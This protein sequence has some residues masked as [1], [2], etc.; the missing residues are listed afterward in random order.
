MQPL[1]EG[2]EAK[3][4]P[5]SDAVVS[6]QYCTITGDQAAETCTS[7]GTGWYKKSQPLRMCT[8]HAIVE[9]K[10]E[11]ADTSTASDSNNDSDDEPGIFDRLRDNNADEDRVARP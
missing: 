5:E 1:H 3:S 7:R 8:G 9:E 6:L 10:P 2:L 11:N 4:F